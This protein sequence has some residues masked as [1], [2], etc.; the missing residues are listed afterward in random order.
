MSDHR[1]AMH[2]A[3]ALLRMLLRR[4]LWASTALAIAASVAGCWKAPPAPLA[5]ADPS[6]PSARTPPVGYRS[7]IEPYVRERP[8]TPAPWRERNEQVAPK[9]KPRDSQ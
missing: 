9:A 1:R 3:H 8:V 6:T 2:A 7:T 4:L 5:G